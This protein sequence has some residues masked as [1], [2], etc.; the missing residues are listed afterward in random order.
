MKEIDE[1]M[2]GDREMK[3][4]DLVNTAGLGHHRIQLRAN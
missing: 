4:L 3:D 1:W 2:D